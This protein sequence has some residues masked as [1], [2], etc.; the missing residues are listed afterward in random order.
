MESQFPPRPLRTDSFQIKGDVRV[1]SPFTAYFFMVHLSKRGVSLLDQLRA[2]Q[3]QSK[4]LP[5]QKAPGFWKNGGSVVH[6]SPD[7]W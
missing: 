5:P 1:L 7:F 6:S 2:L 4:Q 3:A